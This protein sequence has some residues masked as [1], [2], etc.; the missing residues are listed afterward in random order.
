MHSDLD[1]PWKGRRRRAQKTSRGL[2]KEHKLKLL[3]HRNRSDFCDLQL[4][5]P[6]RTPEIARFP[7]QDQGD[8]AMLHCDLRVRWKVAS[9]FRFWAAISEPKTHSFCGIS[10]DLGQSTQKSLAIAIVQ[11]WCAKLKLLG[12]HI[13][14][15]GEGLPRE[16]VGANKLGMSL[17]TQRSQ[18]FWRDSPGLFAGI[19]RGPE[20]LSIGDGGGKQGCGNRPLSTTGTRYGNP[21]STAWMPPNQRL[22]S[23]STDLPV[24]RM[25]EK[26]RYG[27]SVST[28]HRRYGHQLRTPF[29][30][31]PFLCSSQTRSF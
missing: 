3:A 12:P 6:S 20:N 28:A 27:I 30:R 10:F 18:T 4:R 8:Q 24:Q 21:V 7:R 26:S 1:L 11:F 2:K 9:D 25:K 29:L 14:R 22:N 31:T 13:F 16:G 15:R 5:C 17:E 19:C 23:A